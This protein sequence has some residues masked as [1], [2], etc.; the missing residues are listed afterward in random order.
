[1]AKK[2]APKPGTKLPL[3][4]LAAALGTLAVIGGIYFAVIWLGKQAG[5]AVVDRPRYKIRF[6]DIDCPVPPGTDRT[7]F[8]AEVRFLA[9]PPAEFSSADPE[10]MKTLAAAFAKH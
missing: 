3:R 7:A 8:L 6:D 1:M 4:P 9:S 2:A 10:A 5:D